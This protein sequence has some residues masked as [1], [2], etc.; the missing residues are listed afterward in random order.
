[1]TQVVQSATRWRSLEERLARFDPQ[2]H[3]G[4]VMALVPVGN[5]Y[6]PV[7]LLAAITTENR[8]A[9]ADFDAAVGREVW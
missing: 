9:A 6:G 3:G 2:R 1:M 8:H 7:D 5:E 4:E